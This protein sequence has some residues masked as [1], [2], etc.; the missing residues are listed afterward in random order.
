MLESRST[1][2][3]LLEMIPMQRIL[4]ACLV[5]ALFC[6][7]TGAADPTT[8]DA[9]ALLDKLKATY[10]PKNK[11]SNKGLTMIDL[12]RK[13]VTDADLKTIA[14]LTTVRDLK[15][16]GP[17]DK[18]VAGKP[19]YAKVQ[20][21]DDG[22][23]NLAGMTALHSLDLTGT[24]IT[25][26]GLKHLA[27]M[28]DL[29]NLQLSSTKVTDAAVEQLTKLPKLQSLTLSNTKVTEAGVFALKRW[30]GELNITK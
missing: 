23:K 28:K 24:N 15:L 21:T 18:E 30:K 13:K 22:L 16:E 8:E 20:I 26:E 7:V 25:D 11:K 5:F 9:M 2:P 14:V 3:T 6:T 12:S 1:F 19:V 4:A 17:I 10:A 27:G 29:Q